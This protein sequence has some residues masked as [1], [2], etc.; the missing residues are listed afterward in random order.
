MGQID[1]SAGMEEK[2]RAD[3]VSGQDNTGGQVKGRARGEVRTGRIPTVI[4]FNSRQLFRYF[5]IVFHIKFHLTSTFN[6]HM[7][8]T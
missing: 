5:I 8:L 7:M 6:F 2:G 1:G 3:T 4:F